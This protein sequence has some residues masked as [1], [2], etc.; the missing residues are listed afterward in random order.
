MSM[1]RLVLSMTVVGGPGSEV[2]GDFNIASV[3]DPADTR[4]LDGAFPVSSQL[5]NVQTRI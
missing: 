1:A 5:S 2:S 3:D 4:R